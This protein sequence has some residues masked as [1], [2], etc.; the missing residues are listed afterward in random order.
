MDPLT[1]KLTA[2]ILSE[3][4]KVMLKLVQQIDTVRAEQIAS[5]LES[6][7]SKVENGVVALRTKDLKTALREYK[8]GREQATNALKNRPDDDT[9]DD[10]SYVETLKGAYDA[11]ND[12]FST[13]PT[14]EDKL[15]AFKIMVFCAIMTETPRNACIRIRNLIEDLCKDKTI[16]KAL[17]EFNKCVKDP[18]G[19]FEKKAKMSNVTKELLANFFTHLKGALVVVFYLSDKHKKE[20]DEEKGQMVQALRK[21]ANLSNSTKKVENLENIVYCD[22]VTV[23]KVVYYGTVILPVLEKMAKAAYKATKNS[24]RNTST[25]NVDPAKDTIIEASHLLNLIIHSDGNP[26][27]GHIAPIWLKRINVEVDPPPVTL[28]GKLKTLLLITFPQQMEVLKE[29]SI[30][31]ILEGIK[32][33]MTERVLKHVNTMK[34]LS[35]SINT[36]V[37]RKKNDML[38]STVNTMN[39]LSTS[40]S[41]IVQ[42]KKNDMMPTLNAI[43]QLPNSANEIFQK[44]KNHML[45]NIPRAFRNKAISK[46]IQQKMELVTSTQKRYVSIFAS[47]SC[48]G[49][50]YLYSAPR[51]SKKTSGNDNGMFPSLSTVTRMTWKLL[52]NNTKTIL[53]GIVS[54]GVP[55]DIKKGN[56]K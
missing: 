56:F 15:E 12:A 42:R 25:Q 18:T 32:K 40:A 46:I 54:A 45:Q 5:M 26:N 19:W 50:F 49:F 47:F 55:D 10:L 30:M 3:A 43:T 38:E 48:V 2:V 41:K 52:S 8:I 34:T 7:M 11:A 17:K 21:S 35:N 1:F 9:P 53:Y 36:N 33:E 51:L 23:M 6:S 4:P 39:R 37:Q 44:K 28:F 13:V 16:Q 31:M 14:V 29:A 20:C 22:G 27:F 24:K